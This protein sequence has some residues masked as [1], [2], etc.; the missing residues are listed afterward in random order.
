LST[1]D[2]TIGGLGTITSVCSD[3][4]VGF[5]HPLDFAGRTSYGLA[6]ASALYIQNDPLGPAFKVAN[7]GS[8]LGTIDQDRMTGI[9]GPLGP[10]PPS[11][12]VTSTVSYGDATPRTGETDVQL[13]DAAAEATY[14]EL[15][16]NHQTV[17]DAYAPGGE[18][19]TWTVTGTAS[20]TPFVFNGGN[21][22][23]DS[24][25]IADGASYDVP[26]LLYALTR[27][28]SD[29]VDTVDVHS[30]VNDDSSRVM[31]VGVQQ[32]RGGNWVDVDRHHAA[33]VTAGGTATFRLVLKGGST[34]KFQVA[35]PAKARGLQA[36]LDVLGG[37]SYPFERG[38]LGTFAKIKS[39]V[40]N[41]TRNDQARVELDAF[42]KHSVI[43]VR[44]TTP[45]FGRVLT[46]RAFLPV[47]VS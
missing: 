15:A 32:R 10:L 9:S 7:V 20:G 28:K 42:G 5:G 14:Y 2:I 33:R 4:V 47:R 41:M 27:L 12:A 6:G 22:Y 17:M 34:Q 24:Y 23:A 25:S 46:G 3:R 29:T 8:L 13:P 39:A 26:D 19:Q 37:F 36:E 18:Q 40:E 35:V 21:V 30:A 38:G 31:I 45:A 44:T 1:G 43:R 16:V 11:I